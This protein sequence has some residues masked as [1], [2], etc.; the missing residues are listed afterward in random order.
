MRQSVVGLALL[1]GLAQDA[2]GQGN[3][4]VPPDDPAYRAIDRLVDRGL[5]THIIVGQRPY[6]RALMANVAREA[7]ARLDAAVVDDS[8]SLLLDR[9]AVQR[10]LVVATGRNSDEGPSRDRSA[11]ASSPLRVLRLD[12]LLTDAPSRNV[13]ANGLGYVEADLNTFTDNNFGE[14][15]VTGM[16]VS[17][18]SE[19]WIETPHI[20]FQVRPRLWFR[21]SR[22]DSAGRASAEFLALSGR[23]VQG[24]VAL[25]VGREYTFW[26]PD[27]QGGL[28][29]GPNAPALDMIRLASDAPFALPGILRSLG[30]A[31][32]T[33]QVA[34]LGASVN[35]SHSLL[36]S[37]KVTV[38]PASALEVGATFFNH[39][40]GAGA[41]RASTID[42]FVDLIPLL[43]V[44]RHHA[45]STDVSSD[46]LL[47]ID[48]R[49][50]LS[51]IAGVTL[52]GELA[53][54]DFDIHRLYSIF[55]EDA[56]YS[57]GVL[58][59][60]VIVPALSARLAVHTTGIRFYEHHLITNGIAARRFLLGDDLGHQARGAS[61]MLRWERVTGAQVTAN[62]DFEERKNDIFDGTY[63]NPDQT[64]LV[65]RTLLTLPAET[66]AR[67]MVGTSWFTRDRHVMV[68]LS[69]GVERIANFAFVQSAA[70]T[71]GVASTGIAIYP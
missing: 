27:E 40:G 65:F 9:A 11:L 46:K 47:G 19:H 69:G 36:V 48:G 51:R 57:L 70:S 52:F 32:A 39:F 34:D 64:G 6:S 66:R 67:A 13:P 22:D 12:A 8:A 14:R 7:S 55:H 31:A 4:T 58:L 2:V 53:L 62:L 33:M 17:A 56:A 18:Q 50:R 1:A 28:F 16:N 38:K 63:A 23:A 44:F 61:A 71:H 59:P 24:N 60:R 20:A 54:E 45:D 35:N 5:V 30:D 41:K 26:S 25:T 49:I 15:R 29:F 3:A 10:I 37:Y 21:D 43:D 68:R 42:R